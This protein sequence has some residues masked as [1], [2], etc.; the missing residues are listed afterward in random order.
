MKKTTYVRPKG[1]VHQAP[2]EIKARFKIMKN[3][4]L[5]KRI[6]QEFF[7]K[8]EYGSD[9]EHYSALELSGEMLDRLE[10]RNIYYIR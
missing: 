6:F 4:G 2:Q 8:K 5:E 7:I 9:F 10:E 3:D 1:H